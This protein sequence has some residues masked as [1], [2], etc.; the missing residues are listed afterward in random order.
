VENSISKWV[1]KTL[2][3]IGC[4]VV[5]VYA[6][7]QLPYTIRDRPLF[8]QLLGNSLDPESVVEDPSLVSLNHSTLR[9]P[10][11]DTIQFLLIGHAYGSH[12]DRESSLSY[13]PYQT[14]LGNIP[15]IRS[16]DLNMVVFLGDIV[17]NPSNKNF[18]I[19][20][21]EILEWLGHPAFN[22]IGNHDLL[23]PSK[24]EERYGRTFF[25]FQ[26][27]P[28]QM[29][30]LDTEK[31]KCDIVGSQ[32]AMMDVAVENAL[33]DN[34]IH[35]IF[36]FMHK[37]LYLGSNVLYEIQE[38]PAQ[39]NEWICYGNESFKE[40]MEER[41]LPAAKQKG[42]Y[43]VAGDVGAFDGNLSPFYHKHP[44]VQ[45]VVTGSG[46]GDTHHDVVLLVKVEDKKVTFW[47]LSLTGEEV[48]ELEYYDLDYWESTVTL[49]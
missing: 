14:L 34:T 19:F 22:A 48:Y 42:I 24:Y 15:L 28:T 29:I 32:R 20:E 46:L 30:F 1:K 4:I 39:P 40:L 17:R 21:E 9:E 13:P 3:V 26:Y 23:S 33:Q 25:T 5:I 6:F 12:D 49:E 10:Y 45:L 37:V 44:D 38:W 36:V 2:L 27:G 11:Q 16:M 8:N 31:D 35:H 41:L 47:V 18:E 7:N 43:L